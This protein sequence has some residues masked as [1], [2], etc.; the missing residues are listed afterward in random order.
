M[1]GKRGE[2]RL[3]KVPAAPV[4]ERGA[5]GGVVEED[6]AVV[7]AAVDNQLAERLRRPPDHQD[8]AR[9]TRQQQTRALARGA[10]AK[11]LP[12]SGRV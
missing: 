7:A 5:I 2:E 12:A 3:A 8:A 6:G 4:Q 11:G 1:A 10:N 9:Y